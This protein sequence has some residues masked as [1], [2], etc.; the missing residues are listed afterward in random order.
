[1]KAFRF[2]RLAPVLVA[3]AL[4]SPAFAQET[5]P[6]TAPPPAPVAKSTYFDFGV[7]GNFIA[8]GYRDLDFSQRFGVVMELGL[9]HFALPLSFSFGDSVFIVG[10]KPRF[11]LWIQP[12]PNLHEFTIGPGVAP[13]F[14]YW[15]ADM[16]D[17]SV[18]AYEVGI[19]PSVRLRYQVTPEINVIFVPMELDLNFW[20]YASAQ[21]PGFSGSGSSTELAIFYNIQF[22]VGVNF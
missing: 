7:S 18:N 17:G 19:Q 11:Q 12:V 21:F 10:M 2:N 8:I 14:N 15:R 5:V 20:R 1:M 22:L 6:P 4:I 9:G 13:V 3:A 16:L